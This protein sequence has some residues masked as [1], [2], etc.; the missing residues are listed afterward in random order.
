MASDAYYALQAIRD[1]AADLPPAPH[2]PPTS[3][4]DLPEGLL[5]TIIKALVV[6]GSATHTPAFVAVDESCRAL[7]SVACSSRQLRRIVSERASCAAS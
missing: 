2:G 4:A 5:T 3:F 7:A 1:A 6:T